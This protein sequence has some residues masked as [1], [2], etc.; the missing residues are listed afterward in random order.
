MRIKYLPQSPGVP[1]PRYSYQPI[2]QSNSGGSQQMWARGI[3]LTMLCITVWNTGLGQ[4]PKADFSSNNTNSGCAPL[5]AQFKDISTGGS[6]TWWR[7]EFGNGASSS[8]QNPGVIYTEPGTYTITFIAGN[9]TGSDTMVKTAYIEVYGKPEVAFGATPATGCLPLN[10]RFSDSSKAGSGTI[11]SYI[12]DFGDGQIS[13]L[14]NPAHTYTVPGNYEV[15][16]TVQNSYGCKQALQKKAAVQVAGKV[17]GAYNYSYVNACQP[18]TRVQFNNTSASDKPLQYQWSF[19]DGNSSTE[20]SPEHVYSAAGNYSARL[21]SISP[22]GCTDTM[23]QQITIGAVKAAFSVANNACTGTALSFTNT[24][25][26]APVSSTWAFGDEATATGINTS[27]TYTKSG[28]YNVTLYTNFGNCTDSVKQLVTV[29]DKPVTSFTT[30]GVTDACAVPA[31][32]TFTNTTKG[33]VSYLWIF[34]DGSTSQ[35]TNPSHT[36]RQS[37]YYTITLISFNAGGCSDTLTRQKLIHVGPPRITALKDLPYTGCVPS[38]V[39]MS[40]LLDEA[41][42]VTSWRWNFGDGSTSEEAT[43]SHNYTQAGDYTVSVTIRTSSGCTDTYTLQ[44]AVVLAQAPEAAFSATPLQVCGS[45]PI[46]F[47]DESTGDR[48][49]WSWNFGDGQYDSNKNPKHPYQDTGNFTITLVVGN[50]NCFD[51]LVKTRY[52]RIDMPIARFNAEMNCNKPYERTFTDISIGAKSWEWNFGDGQKANT[53]HPA[54]TYADTGT[55]IVQL[56]TRNDACADT[57]RKTIYVVD[58]HP[59]FDYTPGEEICKKETITVT[60]TNYAPQYVK[61]FT[62][63]FG[64]QTE[65]KGKAATLSHVYANTGSYAVKLTITDINGCAVSAEKPILNI[66]VFGSKAQFD[67]TTGICLED[68]KVSFTD[69]SVTDGKHPVT[70]WKWSFGDG[71]T[72]VTTTAGYTHTYTKAGNFSVQLTIKDSYGCRDTITKTNAVVIADPKAVINLQDS[73]FCSGLPVNFANASKGTALSYRWSFGD[74]TTSTQAAPAHSFAKEGSYNIALA[75][76]DKYGCKDSVYK[77]KLVTIANPVASFNLT[78]SFASCPP[79]IASPVNYSQ[80]TTAYSWNFDDGIVSGL[81]KPEHAY[82]QGG[83]YRLTLVAKGHGACY[84]T[85]VHVVTVKGPSGSYTFTPNVACAPSPVAFKGKVKNTVTLA[86]DFGDGTVVAGADEV[87]SH[88]YT[89]HGAYVPKLVLIDSFNCKVG[90]ANRDTLFVRDIK[91]HMQNT[92]QTGCDSALMAFTDS[93]QVWYDKIASYQW[94]FGDKTTSTQANPT[95]YYY[96]SG[97][98]TTKLVVTSAMG[99]KDSVTRVLNVPVYQSPRPRII[100]EDSICFNSS[101]S[102]QGS[103]QHSDTAITSWQ[104]KYGNGQ[105]ANGQNQQ[106]TWPYTGK[107]QVQLTAVNGHGCTGNA[108]RSVTVLSLPVLDAGP[109]TS[110]CL[111]QTL[112]MQPTGADIYNWSGNMNRSNADYGMGEVSPSTGT[113]YYLK[114]SSYFGCVSHDS[115]FVDVKQPTRISRMSAD[116]LCTGESA[117]L[118]ATGAERY[119][120]IPATGLDNPR[121]ANPVATPAATTTYTVIGGDLKGCFSDTQRVTVRVYPIPV[122]DILDSVKNV[123]VGY[124]DT[125]RTYSS[126]DIT[127]WR[128]APATS[129]SCA[130]CPNPV[131][132]SKQDITYTAKVFNEGGCTAQD[133]VTV[134]VLCNGVNVFMP[135]TFSPNN[136]GMNDRFYPRGKG[137]YNIRA[138]RIFNR[139]GQ[140]VYEKVN[141]LANNESYGWDGSFG[142]QPGQSG[143]YVY[144]MEIECN[145][146]TVM[147]YKGNVMLMR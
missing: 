46:S 111:G 62:W 140:A 105:Q 51:T 92:L 12:W 6:A 40:A 121:I 35:E 54:H 131:I 47:T 93:T 82:V 106:Y 122:F 115:L 87:I 60:A 124:P 41:Q 109:D 53:R 104:W 89:N 76:T 5:I 19:G 58:E 94:S 48:D 77:E 83:V 137:L 28:T 31:T 143:V 110:I 136:D 126:P 44:H 85:A 134:H 37:G 139:W 75:V 119:E 29:S 127:T 129:L 70:E 103:D 113:R 90:I 2:S 10:T 80:N 11:T 55:Y 91:P 108:T 65:K 81:D 114:G 84:D 74:G 133:Q 112:R 69:K 59:S 144:V 101:L 27:H 64:D 102:M 125:L 120:W 130:T 43:P 4:T 38:V 25:T 142:G 22:A 32:V 71:N 116:T 42:T 100:A 61:D 141:F 135:N 45:K 132:L 79:L 20:A 98:Y 128:W 36:Y 145:N 15:S 123:N 73:I 67:N 17:T 146:G 97:N 7:W 118:Q 88:T 16:L 49:F 9:A 14:A 72:A 39:K 107:Y 3:I 52:V 147:T 56:I 86:W 33:A 13:A 57:M 63:N 24:S 138:L 78:D 23:V 95:H 96:K 1:L 30:P 21:I 34:G 18:P 117:K 99:C 8:Q 50:K 26:P 68:G 66:A